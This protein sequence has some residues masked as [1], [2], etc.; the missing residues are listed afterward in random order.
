LTVGVG[1]FGPPGPPP[2]R[3]F[4]HESNAASSFKPRRCRIVRTAIE[5]IQGLG[6]PEDLASLSTDLV[7]WVIIATVIILIVQVAMLYTTWL[8]RKVVGRMQDRLGANRVGSSACRAA[9][10]IKMTKRT[11]RPRRRTARCSTSARS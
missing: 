10:M 9:D 5:A 7:M 4:A 3:E 6:L 1:R 2:R 8:E 11:S